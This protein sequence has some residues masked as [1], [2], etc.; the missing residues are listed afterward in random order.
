MSQTP[1]TKKISRAEW[2]ED[3]DA[4]KGHVLGDRLDSDVC[5][6]FYATDETGKGPSLHVHPYDEIFIIRRGRARF[7]VG[8]RVIEAGEGD[9]VLGPA[10]IPHKYENIGDGPLESTDIH[11]SRTWIQTDL[12][13]PD[14]Q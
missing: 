1:R 13:D 14:A 10:N 9:V 3:A 4:W 11:L 7:T 12:E 5:I 2:A 6:L 8:D